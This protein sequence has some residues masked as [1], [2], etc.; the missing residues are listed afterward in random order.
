MKYI[1]NIKQ[2]FDWATK[3]EY[4]NS[5]ILDDFRCTYKNPKRERLIFS[6]LMDMYQKPMPVRRLEEVRDV[7]VFGCFT[8]YSYM[9]LYELTPD[10]VSIW[11]DGSKWL[12]KDRHKG[13]N[14]KSNVPLLEIPL[15]II[16]K[17]KN[18]R[19]CITFNKLLPVNSNQRYNAYLKEIAGICGIQKQLTTHTARHTFATTILLENDCPLSSVKEMLGHAS[20]RTTEIYARTTDIK[21]SNNMKSVKEKLNSKL[22]LTKTGS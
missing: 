11:I 7:Y 3:K 5:N 10:N 2:F 1:K 14:N 18:H 19:Y 8:G 13:D 6:E 16:D 21:V 20:T 22:L 15:Q 9:D 4:M 12:I 17:Y